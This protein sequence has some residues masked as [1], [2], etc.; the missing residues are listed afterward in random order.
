[1]FI[2]SDDTKSDENSIGEK[3]ASTTALLVSLSS[4]E[5]ITSANDMFILFNL[6]A[7]S[8]ILIIPSVKSSNKGSIS[9]S[10]V[11]SVP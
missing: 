3:F 6:S 4:Y 11:L 10:T 8:L 9:N 2:P 5:V 7:R 1:M